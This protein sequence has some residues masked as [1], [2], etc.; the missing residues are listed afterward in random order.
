MGKSLQERTCCGV[1]VIISW[2]STV[3]IFMY[4]VADFVP[5]AGRAK[6]QNLENALNLF[7][8]EREENQP[9]C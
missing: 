3:F 6:V 2:I 9:C 1:A 5:L 4:A 8:K 7:D